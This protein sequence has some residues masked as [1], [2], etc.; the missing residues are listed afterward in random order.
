MLSA[1][2]SI[3]H[4]PNLSHPEHLFAVLEESDVF[5]R[6]DCDK[7]A[8]QIRGKKYDPVRNRVT[9]HYIFFSPAESSSVSR[10]CWR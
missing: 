7:I 4:V 3:L 5:S 6:S 2:T 1:F 10:S 9:L 8:K